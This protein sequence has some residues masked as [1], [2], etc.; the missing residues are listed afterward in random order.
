M[1]I[2]R[3]KSQDRSVSYLYNLHCIAKNT[4]T[5]DLNSIQSCTANEWQSYIVL[6]E[7]K[8]Q[9][10]SNF[11]C[12]MWRFYWKTIAQETD[13]Q[14]ALRNCSEEIGKESR[15]HIS[16][17]QSVSWISPSWILLRAHSQWA[18]AVGCNLILEELE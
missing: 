17:V 12:S 15:D 2:H 3:A 9:V 7:K 10:K 14:I 4:V 16:K 13:S 18:T 1:Q 11:M 8:I 5:G 6:N